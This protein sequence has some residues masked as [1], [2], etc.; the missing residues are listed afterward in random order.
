MGSHRLTC[1]LQ[2]LSVFTHTHTRHL[3]PQRR[4]QGKDR[5]SKKS[6]VSGLS[7]R[8]SLCNKGFWFGFWLC[9]PA[10]AASVPC[11]SE[12]QWQPSSGTLPSPSFIRP[13]TEG[14][15]RPLSCPALKESHFCYVRVFQGAGILGRRLPCRAEW[16]LDG[17]ERHQWLALTTSFSPVVGSAPVSPVPVLPGM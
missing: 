11:S 6:L 13:S 4:T 16:A 15:L 8:L 3:C 17:Q 14:R 12:R 1:V 7:K 9:A 10:S 2:G 5:F